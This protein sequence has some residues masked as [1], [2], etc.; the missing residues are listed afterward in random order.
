MS[1]QS[2]TDYDNMPSSNQPPAGRTG[3]LPSHFVY[4]LPFL[5]LLAACFFMLGRKTLKPLSPPQP[6][7][8]IY[9]ADVGTIHLKAGPWGDLQYLPI[10]IAAPT[11]LLNVQKTEESPVRWFFKDYTRDGLAKLLKSLNLPDR[12]Q[13]Q[14]LA[15]EQLEIASNGV[16][17]KPS[18]ELVFNLPENAITAFYQILAL[19][20]ENNDLRETVPV[21][22]LE[23]MTEANGVAKQT[24]ALFQQVSWRYHD[25]FICYCLPHLL[26]SLSTYEAKNHFMKAISRQK[27][28]LLKMW[29]KPNADLDALNDYWGKACWSTDARA[30]LESLAKTPGG[31]QLDIIELLPPLPTQLLYTYPI[32]Q[33]PLFG[34]VVRQDCMWTSLNFFR[35]PPDPKFGEADYI[36]EKLKTEYYQVK[37]DPRFGDIVMFTTPDLKFIHSAVYLADNIVFTRNGDNPRNPWMLSTIDDLLDIYSINVPEGQKLT[38]YYFRSKYY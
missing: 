37:T 20:P 10:S 19:S 8:H 30:M 13:N 22:I 1:N 32:P 35:D 16:V 29:V 3:I 18:R 27:T 38:L 36:L 9:P 33:N 34:Q 25:N 17:V 5:V 23:Y 2:R 26:A 15:P 12:Q 31:G 24:A 21:S 28:M 4:Y 7:V 6:V 14:L 11:A